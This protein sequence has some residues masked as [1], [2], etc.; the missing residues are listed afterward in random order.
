[1]K[2]NAG[3]SNSLSSVGSAILIKMDGIGKVRDFVRVKKDGIVVQE[4]KGFL[5]EVAKDDGEVTPLE[6]KLHD[7]GVLNP[8][9]GLYDVDIDLVVD[10]ASIEE[11]LADVYFITNSDESGNDYI[12]FVG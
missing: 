2:K 3:N 4:L 10:E 7:C 8:E 1:M 5:M 11:E 9:D 12:L 6:A